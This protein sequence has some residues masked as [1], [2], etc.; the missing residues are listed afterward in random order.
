MYIASHMLSLEYKSLMTIAMSKAEM[1]DPLMIVLQCKILSDMN[2][3]MSGKFF[4]QVKE[5]KIDN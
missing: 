5:I 4:G 1:V 3:S 2:K